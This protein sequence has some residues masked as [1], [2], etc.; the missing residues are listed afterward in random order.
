MANGIQKQKQEPLTKMWEKHE[1]DTEQSSANNPPERPTD[2]GVWGPRGNQAQSQYDW[3]IPNACKSIFAAGSRNSTTLPRSC[4]SCRSFSLTLRGYTQR[5][6][7]ETPF[8]WKSEKGIR[9]PLRT[10]A[11]LTYN[12]LRNG[13]SNA[14]AT[15]IP[16]LQASENQVKHSET[17]KRMAYRKTLAMRKQLSGEVVTCIHK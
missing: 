14:N 3:D 7:A 9:T 8:G 5:M 13:L 12:A 4:H 2:C 16:K 6:A 15:C 17:T 1:S 10:E 11:G